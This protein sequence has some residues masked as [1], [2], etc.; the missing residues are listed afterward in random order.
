MKETIEIDK[1]LFIKMV[2]ELKDNR[3]DSYETWEGSGVWNTLCTYCSRDIM[4]EEEHNDR[5]I[6]NKLEPYEYLLGKEEDNEEEPITTYSLSSINKKGAW[7]KVC[8]MKGIPYYPTPEGYHDSTIYL[9]VK[10]AQEIGM[11]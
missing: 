6:L 2:Q 5:C 10:E 11:L 4:K 1:E 8:T 7:E 3:R 9:T